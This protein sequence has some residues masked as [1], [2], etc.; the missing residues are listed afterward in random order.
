MLQAILTTESGSLSDERA[1][2]GINP[3]GHAAAA[4]A[5]EL[6]P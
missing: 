4:D 1:D 6:W 3:L 5:P 2:S